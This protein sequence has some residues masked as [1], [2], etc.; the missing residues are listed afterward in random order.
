MSRFES[1]VPSHKAKRP[2]SAGVWLYWLV[3][4]DAN[5]LR[6]KSPG[7]IFRERSEPEGPGTGMCR[8]ILT[9]GVGVKPLTTGGRRKYPGRLD[10]DPGTNGLIPLP[11]KID[12]RH[13]D[14]TTG[15]ITMSVF[16]FGRRYPGAKTPSGHCRQQKPKIISVLK[17]ADFCKSLIAYAFV[18]MQQRGFSCF[19]CK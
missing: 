3:D 7:A 1:S 17:L 5:L 10:S 8:A 4:Q 18:K 6:Q 11:N 19:F 16:Q 15:A 2:P 14:H 12:I 13:S 9:S